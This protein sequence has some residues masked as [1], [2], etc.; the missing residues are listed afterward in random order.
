[1]N[2]RIP[3]SSRLCECGRPAVKQKQ[4]FYV[5]LRCCELEDRN[6]AWANR[7]H[8]AG[9]KELHGKGGMMQKYNE[10]IEGPI[11]GASLNLLK[12]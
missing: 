10:V 2:P 12:V 4:S 7:K 6:A 5:C 9:E 1:M 8:V 3:I 11:C